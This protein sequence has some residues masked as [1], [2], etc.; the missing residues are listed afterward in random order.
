VSDNWDKLQSDKISSKLSDKLER[1][2]NHLK[3]VILNP[4]KYNTNIATKDELEDLTQQI[5]ELR[6]FL[7]DVI[8][9]I[10]KIENKG[11]EQ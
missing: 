10:N 7:D 11:S 3:N 8:E 1:K 5:E 6:I 2:Y 9:R 4:D